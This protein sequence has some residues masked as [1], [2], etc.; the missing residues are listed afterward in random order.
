MSVNMF[1]EIL[2]TKPDFSVLH[3]LFVLYV[4]VLIDHNLV[5]LIVIFVLVIG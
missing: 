2:C 5:G 3:Y 4:I 1:L